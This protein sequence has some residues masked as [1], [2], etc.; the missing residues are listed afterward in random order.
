MRAGI[1]KRESMIL[2]VTP[3][4][5][6]KG[7]NFSE[8]FIGDFFELLNNNLDKNFGAY[9]IEEFKRFK[10]ILNGED[11]FL[12]LDE[13]TMN[14]YIFGKDNDFTK[15]LRRII[16]K[17]T[18]RD[19]GE[20]ISKN[21]KKMKEEIIERAEQGIILDDYAREIYLEHLKNSK[22]F[23]FKKIVTYFKNLVSDFKFSLDCVKNWFD[24]TKIWPFSKAEDGL[25]Y[26]LLTLLVNAIILLVGSSVLTVLEANAIPYGNIYEYLPLIFIPQTTYLV[27][28]AK[29]IKFQAQ[30]RLA[31]FLEFINNKKIVK[32]KIEHLTQELKYG[33]KEISDKFAEILPEE[34]VNVKEATLPNKILQELSEMAKKLNYINPEERKFYGDKIDAIATE[35]IDR[36]KKI[37]STNGEIGLQLNSD[38]ILALNSDILGKIVLLNEEIYQKIDVSIKNQ[39]IDNQYQILASQIKKSYATEETVIG[40]DRSPRARIPNR[41][42]K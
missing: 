15:R 34:V 31:R 30:N 21:D 1:E 39:D 8:M 4:N 35:Y 32:Y 14:N 18:Q 33:Y 22:K 13:V 5:T 19:K 9:Y 40:G 20:L 11:Y 16:D 6:I 12:E 23:S 26:F 42:N 28:A 36:L 38:N 10:I 3:F 41:D 2:F 17:T 27:P 37:N 24:K 7:T 29:L 25:H